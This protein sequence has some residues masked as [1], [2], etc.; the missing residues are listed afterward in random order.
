LNFEVKIAPSAA[1]LLKKYKRPLKEKMVAEAKKI[2]LDPYGNEKLHPPLQ[3]CRSYH[4]NWRGVT[5]RNRLQ[6][7]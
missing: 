6:D 5:Y 4:F 3:E 2:P 1:R 7:L